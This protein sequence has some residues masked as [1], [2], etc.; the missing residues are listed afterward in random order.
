MEGG[1]KV[2]LVLSAAN[3]CCS[4]CL[5]QLCRRILPPLTSK[6]LL[7]TLIVPYKLS[8]LKEGLQTHAVI[9]TFQNGF[10]GKEI[11]GTRKIVPICG[12]NL[13]HSNEKNISVLKNLNMQKNFI[14]GPI[15]Y[16]VLVVRRQ[17]NKDISEFFYFIKR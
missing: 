6:E 17:V 2:Y 11:L 14:F 9:I 7:V 3:V 12:I 4:S 13:C 8:S 5:W 15:V 16:H 10:Q 1:G